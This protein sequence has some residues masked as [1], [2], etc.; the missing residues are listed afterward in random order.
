MRLLSQED[1]TTAGVLV[2]F[3]VRLLVLIPFAVF[4][5][6]GFPRTFSSLLAMTGLYCAIVG[7]LRRENPF[8][9]VFT[10]FDEAAGYTCLSA[11]IWQLA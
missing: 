8:G 6:I 9:P 1:Q 7:N 10:H 4:A 3:S 11:I 5:K 2:R